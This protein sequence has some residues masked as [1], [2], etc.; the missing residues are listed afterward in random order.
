MVV[1]T[2]VHKLH[3]HLNKVNN[4]TY[5]FS[6]MNI[7]IIKQLNNPSF[8]QISSVR[9]ECTLREN[10]YSGRPTLLTGFFFG[11]FC[12]FTCVKHRSRKPQRNWPSTAFCPSFAVGERSGRCDLYYIWWR[13]LPDRRHGSTRVPGHAFLTWLSLWRCFSNR[14]APG[15]DN[16]C[17][18]SARA[19]GTDSPSRTESQPAG[20]LSSS[21]PGGPP[22]WA[23][24][25]DFGLIGPYCLPWK[26]LLSCE[27]NCW[28]C[29][30]IT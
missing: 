21:Q 1:Y 13:S 5:I 15:R 8:V 11:F 17:Q 7:N 19:G 26:V 30:Y 24:P 22:C 2:S 20:S 29:W 16:W 25:L 4:C 18:R 6:N 3:I 27:P 14:S 23:R 12:C 28:C 10:I 9:Y